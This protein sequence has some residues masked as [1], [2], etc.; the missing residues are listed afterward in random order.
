MFST[1]LKRDKHY[2]INLCKYMIITQFLI[3]F[4]W[5]SLNVT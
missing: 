4:Y 3:V 1:E 2:Y 5:Q